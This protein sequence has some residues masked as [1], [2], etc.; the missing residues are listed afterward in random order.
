MTCK[1]LICTRYFDA[2]H[3]KFE[4]PENWKLEEKLRFCK[5]MNCPN[6][7]ITEKKDSKGRIILVVTCDF[8]FNPFDWKPTTHEQ[9]ESMF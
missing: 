7:S 1:S 5:E 6:G 3:C 4:I 8:S 9:R 2:K